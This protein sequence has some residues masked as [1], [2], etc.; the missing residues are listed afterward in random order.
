M[1]KEKLITILSK[2]TG[3]ERWMVDIVVN[4]FATEV[5]TQLLNGESIHMRGF[6][7]FGVKRTKPKVARIIHKKK[8]IIIPEHD[9]PFFKVSEVLRLKIKE[10]SLKTQLPE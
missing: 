10:K 3:I 4:A 6:G 2:K 8:K 9:Q 5:S 1:T 7:Q